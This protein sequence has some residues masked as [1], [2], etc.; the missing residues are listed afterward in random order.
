[1]FWFA[2]S[3]DLQILIPHLKIN[4]HFSN[5]LKGILPNKTSW[6]NVIFFKTLLIKYLRP[7]TLK[8][9]LLNNQ[10]SSI[11]TAIVTTFYGFITK[12]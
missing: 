7:T 12:N 11:T 1:M 3:A 6:S 2:S 9:I 5:I 10:T 8:Q 4:I